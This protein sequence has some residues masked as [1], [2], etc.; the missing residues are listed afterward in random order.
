MAILKIVGLS[1]NFR[2]LRAIDR[3]DM[4]VEKGEIHGLIGPNGSGK[5]TLFNLIS[6]LLTATEGKVFFESADITNLKPH[7]I[8]KMG[9]SRTFQRA[10]IMDKVSVLDNVMTGLHCRTGADVIGTLLKPAFLR[11]AQEERTKHRALELLEFVGISN[12]AGRL[13][14]EL[15]WVEAQLM[16]IARSLATEPKLLLLDEPTA[17]MGAKETEQLQK[18]IKNIREMGITVIMVSHDI[19][20]VAGVSDLVTVIEFGKKIADGAPTEIQNNLQVMEA[21]LGKKE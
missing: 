21:Y 15:V 20:L 6:G 8:T 3:L 7:V 18:L 10:H 13:A 9:I 4:S 17:G 14:S 5:T 16:Q 11:S 19:R 2:G 1:K 12:L